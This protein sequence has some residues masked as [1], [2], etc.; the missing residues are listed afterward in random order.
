MTTS[1]N[2]GELLDLRALIE[3]AIDQCKHED[4][5]NALDTLLRAKEKAHNIDL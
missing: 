3:Y 5:D 1:E 4:I 2:R